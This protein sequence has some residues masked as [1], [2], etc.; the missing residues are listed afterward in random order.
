MCPTMEPS[1]SEFVSS[2]LLLLKWL[3]AQILT[4]ILAGHVEHY[5]LGSLVLISVVAFAFTL[6]LTLMVHSATL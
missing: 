2:H 5:T 6:L 4:G 1:L 3:D